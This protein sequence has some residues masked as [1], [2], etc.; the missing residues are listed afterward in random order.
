M[1][2][3]N[4]GGFPSALLETPKNLGV[5]S[6]SILSRDPNLSTKP[7][8]TQVENGSGFWKEGQLNRMDKDLTPRK[9]NPM[10]PLNFRWFP[11]ALLETPKKGDHLAQNTAP[12]V[13]HAP[14]Q[15]ARSCAE[16]TS[17]SF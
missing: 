7:P 17:S 14:G 13:C 2:P 3:L 15:A 1:E 16:V 9:K 12:Y 8:E 4:L 11:S 5:P 10:E 6:I